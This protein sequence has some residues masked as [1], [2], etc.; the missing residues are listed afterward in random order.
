MLIEDLGPE[1]RPATTREAAEAAIATHAT[2]TPAGLPRLDEEDLASL[3]A[4]CLARL[5]LL[6]A[7]DRWQD[8]T[9]ITA[10][11]QQL[12]AIAADR[13]KYAELPP[14]GLCHSEFHPTSLHIAN[15]EWR[16]LDWARAFHGPGLLD[17]ASWQNTVEAPDFAAFDQLVAAYIAAGGPPEALAQRGGLSADRWAYG[18]HRLWIVDWYLH[19][20]TTWIADPTQD[21]IYQQVIHR[22][23][24]EAV[25]CLDSR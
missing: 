20:A 18:W 15:D 8:A 12:A 5:D 17:L 9:D 1:A 25:S 23:L 10:Q 7:A 13:A 11:L 22:H 16:L 4:S 6:R 24:A 14:F 19:Q 2:P 21:P 3:P